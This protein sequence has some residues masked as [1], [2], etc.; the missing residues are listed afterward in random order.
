AVERLLHHD[1]G[2][3]RFLGRGEQRITEQAAL[4]LGALVLQGVDEGSFQYGPGQ[5]DHHAGRRRPAQRG[6][7]P[8]PVVGPPEPA[9]GAALVAAVTRATSRS[10]F[11]F[12]WATAWA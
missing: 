11:H 8:A 9:L 7:C 12:A 5:P 2:G 1:G 10:P 4:D 6:H 3:R